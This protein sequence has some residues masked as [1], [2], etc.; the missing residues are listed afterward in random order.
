MQQHIVSSKGRYI[1]IFSTC[2][3]LF[4][5]CVLFLLY[6][7]LIKCF[8]K[9]LWSYEMSIH[10]HFFHAHYSIL[11]N[12]V[13]FTILSTFLLS[14]YLFLCKCKTFCPRH[15]CTF[16]YIQ[17]QLLHKSYL[18]CALPSTPLT[19]WGGFVGFLHVSRDITKMSPVKV[20]SADCSTIQRR[21]QCTLVFSILK[22]FGRSHWGNRHVGY[23]H[24][25][26][27]SGG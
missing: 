19:R 4:C 11:N 24:A 16:I 18:K 21:F 15:K 14:E 8:L 10:W 5:K 9:I 27:I 25:Q 1:I 26:P 3:L 20:W 17:L 2:D 22:H 23:L 7:C 13:V 12:I 6:L